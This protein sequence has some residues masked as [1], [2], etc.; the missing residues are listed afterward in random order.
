MHLFQSLHLTEHIATPPAS[1]HIVHR[2][3]GRVLWEQT[4][5]N[6]QPTAGRDFLILQGYG[7][8]GLGTNGFNYIALSNDP[9]TETTA[10]TS[11]SNEI[12]TNG[13]ARVQG[14][15]T[16]VA[17]TNLLTI[18]KTF[19]ATGSQSVQ[20]AALFTASSGGIMNHA[21]AFQQRA[22]V[23]TDSLSLTF[24]ITVG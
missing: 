19:T 11:L 24:T 14:T 17:G 22:L 23:T 12:T 8:T 6:L 9:L 5:T 15:Y 18:A 20:K 10:S 2:R 4:V 3:N 16:H 7:T 1:V 13:F 21:L